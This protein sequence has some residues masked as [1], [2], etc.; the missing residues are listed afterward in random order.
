M[1]RSPPGVDEA[2]KVLNEALKLDSSAVR[3]LFELEI[4]VNKEL[5]DHPTIQVGESFIDP[6]EGEYVIRPIGLINGLFG[7]DEGSWGYI[8]MERDA[9][10]GHIMRFM[11]TPRAWYGPEDGPHPSEDENANTA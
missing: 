6:R 2:I 9:Q 8:A 10:D 4:S 11:R 1:R 3:E 7:C 5:A